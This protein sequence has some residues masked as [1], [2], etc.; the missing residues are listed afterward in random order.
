M[1]SFKRL[2]TH[3]LLLQTSNQQHRVLFPTSPSFGKLN[4]SIELPG[5]SASVRLVYRATISV[6]RQLDLSMMQA[7]VSSLFSFQ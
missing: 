5:H 2:T 3:D 6:P 7:E 4:N 1:E